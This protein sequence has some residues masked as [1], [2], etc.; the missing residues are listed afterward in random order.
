MIGGL[1][2]VCFSDNPPAD[3]V[4]LEQAMAPP[5]APYDI[6]NAKIAQQVDEI[7]EGNRIQSDHRRCPQ[8]KRS[9]DRRYHRDAADA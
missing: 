4:D 3:I 6:P 1:I 9:C 8:R 5:L 7:E 2:Y